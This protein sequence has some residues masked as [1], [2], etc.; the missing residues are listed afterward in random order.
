MKNKL[1]NFALI[2][3]INLIFISLANSEE[4]NFEAN[5]IELIDKDKRIIAKKNVKI[6]TN[7]ETIYADEMDYDKSKQIIKAKGNILLEIPNEKIKIFGKNL[8]YFKNKELMILDKSIR[9]ELSD[10][11]LFTTEQAI[12]DIN[13]KKININ[14]YS[15]FKDIAGNKVS[16]KKSEFL[17]INKLLKIES[18]DLIDELKTSTILIMQ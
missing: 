4:I 7:A 14:Y 6:F 10:K 16:A 9:I 13:N 18:V 5:I 17:L 11:F 1:K 15:E 2:I 12:Y 3:F 8:T